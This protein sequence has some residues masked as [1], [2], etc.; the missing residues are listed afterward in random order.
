M[1]RNAFLL[2]GLVGLLIATFLMTRPV[3]EEMTCPL[4]QL[5]IND[6]PKANEMCDK[7][8]GVLK[9]GQCTCPS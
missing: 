9:D 6:D 4:S 3:R 5:K 7:A 1:K 2:V 8:G